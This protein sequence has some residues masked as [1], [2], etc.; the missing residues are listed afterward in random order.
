MDETIELKQRYDSSSIAKLET[1]PQT[2]QLVPGLSL[3]TSKCEIPYYASDFDADILQLTA[4]TS[5]PPAIIPASTTV[6][7]ST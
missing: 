2:C 7:D 6:A 4:V 3:T 1:P 5:T